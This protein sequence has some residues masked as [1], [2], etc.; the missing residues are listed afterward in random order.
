[1]LERPRVV[2]KCRER[3]VREP[4]HRHDAFRFGIREGSDQDAVDDAERRRARSDP[5]RQKRH[6]DGREARASPQPAA[7]VPKVAA[8]IVEPAPTPHVSRTLADQGRVA[9]RPTG[10]PPRVG[11]RG[12]CLALPLA[13]QVQVESELLLEIGVGLTAA[14]IGHQAAQPERPRHHVAPPASAG[15]MTRPTAS[16]IR[17]QRVASRSSCRRPARVRA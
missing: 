1:M 8:E 13:L 6:H 10:G 9:Q 17:S 2:A 4:P 5:E 7:S 14:Q 12:A 16:T 3:H 15:R 11:F